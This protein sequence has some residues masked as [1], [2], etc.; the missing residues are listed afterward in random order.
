VVVPPQF[1]KRAVLT[2][3]VNWAKTVCDTK[4]LNAGIRHLREAM[5]QNGYSKT[6]FKRAMHHKNKTTTEKEKPIGVAVLL[7]Q[8][9]TLY[10][11][12]RLLNKFDS[13]RAG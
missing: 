5:K 3:L 10:M 7:F 6:D 1:T 2:T 12:C 9:T 11:I 4:S 8:H 13:P